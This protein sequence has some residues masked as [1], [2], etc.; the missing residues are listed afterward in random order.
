MKIM[1]VETRT[2]V[3]FLDPLGNSGH[4]VFTGAEQ[5]VEALAKANQLR[6]KGMRLVTT[7][8]ENV[9]RVGLD[10]ADSVVDGKLPSGDTYTW[11][12]RRTS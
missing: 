10:G 2:I 4:R 9:D 11:M 8:T 6:C 12:K 5:L 7:A 3:Y 1:L